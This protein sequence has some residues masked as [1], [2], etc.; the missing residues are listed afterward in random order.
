MV[1]RVNLYQHMG[2]KMRPVTLRHGLVIRA[3][4]H[5][6]FLCGKWR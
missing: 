2:C 4:L 5:I 6:T 1:F 3:R